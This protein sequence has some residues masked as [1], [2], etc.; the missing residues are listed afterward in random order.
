MK[1]LIIQ[2]STACLSKY[3]YIPL[4]VMMLLWS[5]SIPIPSRHKTSVPLRS[6]V[7][8]T[9]AVDVMDVPGTTSV[10]AN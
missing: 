5:G 3:K 8:V 1:I 4:S 7:A 2:L 10:T 6:E 9:V